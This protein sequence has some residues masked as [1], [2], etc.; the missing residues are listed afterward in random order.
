MNKTVD[1]FDGYE[2]TCGSRRHRF[3][4]A[5]DFSVDEHGILKIYKY[6]NLLQVFKVWDNFRVVYIT[7]TV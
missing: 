1:I 6:E 4:N 5:T 2:V 7:A 3:V